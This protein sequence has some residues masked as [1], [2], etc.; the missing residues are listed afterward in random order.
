MAAGMAAAAHLW[1]LQWV[2]V[3]EVNLQPAEVR[4]SAERCLHE[5]GCT[6][7]R[8]QH[9]MPA[10]IGHSAAGRGAADVE[11]A[12]AAGAG[13]GW[14]EECSAVKGFE[15]YGS[16]PLGSAARGAHLKISPS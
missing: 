6:W 16:K 5:A 10:C 7:A 3:S 1:G 14:T 15:G 8:A 12:G 11:A 2:L 13:P 9:E 4:G